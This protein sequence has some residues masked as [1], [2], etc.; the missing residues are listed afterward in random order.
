MRQAQSRP[1]D[2]PRK[3]RGRPAR[4]FAKRAGCPRSCARGFLHPHGLEASF[5][6]RVA[7]DVPAI[8]R[9]RG[10]SDELDAS[11]GQRRLE[12]IRCVHGTPNRPGADERVDFVD[13]EDHFRLLP[14][15]FDDRLQ[16]L[17]EFAAILRSSN[18]GGHGNLHDPRVAQ[19]LLAIAGC[20]PLRQPLHDPGLADARFADEDRIGFALLRKNPRH[21]EN[22]VLPP[23]HRLQF[24]APRQFGDVPA[25]KRERRLLHIC[26]NHPLFGVAYAAAKDSLQS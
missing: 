5:E 22:L 15:L 25:E 20:N 12:D 9:R 8:L 24:A 14:G 13:K 19:K 18:E 17:L 2:A 1:R 3:E 4:I 26:T 23:D 6:R 21:P 11:T 10:R 16:S 7:F